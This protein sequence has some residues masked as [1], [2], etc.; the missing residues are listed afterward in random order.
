MAKVGLEILQIRQFLSI[1][2]DANITL[3]RYSDSAGSYVVLD[4]ENISVYKQLYRAAKAKLKLQIK[5][6]RVQNHEPEPEPEPDHSLPSPPPE[7]TDVQQEQPQQRCS[8]LDTVLRV[9]I[10]G[11]VNQVDHT[12]SAAPAPPPLKASMFPNVPAE[13]PAEDDNKISTQAE[14]QKGMKLAKSNPASTPAVMC[15]GGPKFVPPSPICIDCNHCGTG[16]PDAHYHCSI[17]DDGDYDLCQKCIDAGVLCPGEGHWLIKR[18]VS[19]G[20]IKYNITETIAPRKIP[21]PEPQ[22]E[23]SSTREHTTPIEIEDTKAG[24]RTCNACFRCMLHLFFLDRWI[25]LGIL[26]MF[27]LMKA[28]TRKNSLTAKIAETMT[29]ASLVFSRTDMVTILRILSP[30]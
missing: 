5:V 1:P 2:D 20:R 24:E 27:L 4:S 23:L 30:L 25:Y 8:Y 21:E 15:A 18:T 22:V 16:V 7:S 10:D 26:L 29:C 19:D 28:S 12:T 14:P 17:C 9:P 3:E 13:N 11:L 6:T